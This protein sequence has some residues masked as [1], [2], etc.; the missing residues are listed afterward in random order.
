M[1]L[2]AP[3]RLPMLPPARPFVLASSSSHS[4]SEPAGHGGVPKSYP[5]G[6]FDMKTDFWRWAS[7]LPR[8]ILA[9]N[10]SFGRFL[11]ATFPLR[12]S[13]V[14]NSDTALFPLPVPRPGCFDVGS[15]PGNDLRSSSGA[16]REL[17]LDRLLH[18]VAMSLN[19]LHSNF[20][21]VPASA[22]RRRPSPV[23]LQV[24]DRLRL[25]LRAC[26]R[27]TGHADSVPLC[28]GR[29]GAHVVARLAE[30]SGFLASVGLCSS[31]YVGR[32]PPCKVH[33]STGGPASLQPYRDSDPSRLLITGT[34]SW[35]I[36]RHLEWEPE[37]LLPFRCPRIL[38]SIP[39]NSLPH[40]FA[41]KDPCDT[42]LAIFDLWRS[43]GLLHFFPGPFE[44]QQLSRTFGAYKNEGADRMIG[45][46]R[47]PNA[48]EGRVIGPSTL[49]PPGQQL[50][51]LSVP[52]WTHV[53]VGA[54]TDRADFYH[55]IQVSSS[56]ARS[57]VIGPGVP[58]HR[59]AA[60]GFGPLLPQPGPRPLLAPGPDDLLYG[61]F[62]ALFQ[63]DHAG[64]E[65]ATSGHCSLLVDAGLLGPEVRI[66]GRS[67]VPLGPEWHGLIIDDFYALSA[68]PLG[69]TTGLGDFS[70]TIPQSLFDCS[71]A[72]AAV[73]RAKEAYHR[74]GVRGSD[75]KDVLGSVD[76]RAGGAHVDSTL[77]TVSEGQV[78]VG[79]PPE[80]RLALSYLSLKGAA[81]G[82]TTPELCSALSGSW[83]SVLL[84]RR[85]LGACLD[86][87]FSIAPGC[88]HDQAPDETIVLPRSAA[89]ELAVLSA[90]APLAVSNVAAPFSRF[91]YCT[92]ASL[93]KGAVCRAEV[94]LE[95]S[96]ALWAHSG[97][98]GFYTKLDGH[99]AGKDLDHAEGPVESPL[100]FAPSSGRDRPLGLDFD[101]V[102]IGASGIISSSFRAA[103]L[104]A[105]IPFSTGLP[106]DPCVS[107]ASVLDLLS[108]LAPRGRLRSFVA[109]LPLSHDPGAIQIAKRSKA[110]FNLC[111]NLG[112]P[113]A[114]LGPAGNSSLF[115]REEQQQSAV[116][117]GF[118]RSCAFGLPWHL[119]FELLC[120]S[121]DP[122]PLLAACPGC[123]SHDRAPLAGPRVLEGSRTFVETL[124][125]LLRPAAASPEPTSRTPAEGFEGVLA[126]DLLCSFQWECRRAWR[127]DSPRHINCLESDSLVQLYR[128]LCVQ[129]GDTRFPVLTDSAVCLGSHQK[130]RS[131]ARLPLS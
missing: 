64:V 97:K 28:F 121:F 24:L 60:A 105:G 110:L 88:A 85:P 29:R 52:R 38:H 84:Y 22:L 49:L 90:L 123:K 76:F 67:P 6:T 26:S 99:P 27:S 43:K 125:S 37:L 32:E 4:F 113:C 18:V 119:S 117:F 129:G 20:R 115:S 47:G 108:Y 70:Q 80:K 100:S 19:F 45:D 104:K 58:R 36:D 65:F 95:V 53:L 54:S 111:S 77:E 21:H 5:A 40:P 56:R 31:S 57:N 55:Q 103:G 87:F 128:D 83:T 73:L 106:E 112:V 81:Y 94:G 33:R 127:W 122:G 35:D 118:V 101:F 59:L 71:R 48:R 62:G 9:T 78:L 114:L 86:K 25:L 82:V 96:S 12:W 50:V 75:H 120:S 98:K 68:E 102:E 107:Q 124:I 13:S 3:G 16:R 11:A 72:T 17:L 51:N 15:D 30:L 66:V 39:P 89:Q 34:G 126:N 1:A 109:F 116:S 41:S 14:T 74:D 79:S 2:L 61:G 131:S 69:A 93:A 7:A 23:Q 46:R 91:A 44:D 42:A 92:D 130:G 63:G 8:L 10:T